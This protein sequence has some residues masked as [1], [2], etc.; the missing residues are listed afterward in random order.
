MIPA[1]SSI[2]SGMKAGAFQ[3]GLLSDPSVADNAG[4]QQRFALVK[5]PALAYHVLMLNGRNK[6]LDNVTGPAGDRLRGRPATGHRHRR[7]RRRHRHRT[8]HQPRLPVQPD[9]RTAVHAG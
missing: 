4:Q 3:L 1:E 2:L 6:P 5:Q 7:V 9:R 8:D